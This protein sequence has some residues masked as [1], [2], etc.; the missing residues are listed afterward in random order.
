VRG[1]IDVPA[2]QT[3]NIRS[4]PGTAYSLVGSLPNAA[5]VLIMCQTRGSSVIGM[6][7]ATT[8]WDRLSSGGYVS[9][10]FVYTGTNGQVAPNC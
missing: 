6:W 8:L 10:G 4:G 9:D 5:T 7:G 1:T 2:G 3:L